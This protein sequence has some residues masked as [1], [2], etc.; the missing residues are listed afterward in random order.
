MGMTATEKIFARASGLASVKAGET[1]YP[2]PEVVI[3]HDG[4]V[5]SSKAQMDERGIPK[6][7][8]AERVVFATDHAVIYTTPQ[9]VARGAAIRKAVAEWGVKNFYDVGQGGHG[10]IFPMEMG[11]VS[12][13]TFAFAND[14]H[15]SNNGAIGAVVAR[16]G[17]EIVCV[18]ATGTLWIEVPFSIKVN[19]TGKLQDG[20]FG[21]DFGYRVARNFTNGTFKADWDYRV[22]E[23]G[24]PALEHLNLAQ[25]VAMCNTLT[26]IG[27]A[28]VFFPPSQE[29]IQW[30]S[31]RARRPF[32]PVYSDPDAHYEAEFTFDLGTLQPQIV[33]PGAPDQ[34]ADI[35][36][37]LGRKVDHAYVGSCGSGMY[38]DLQVTARALKGRKV[39]SGTRLFIVP[40]TVASARRMVAEGL[41]DIFQE[42]GAIILPAGCGPCT[43]G[44]GA[45]LAAGE[46]SICTAATNYAGRMGDKAAEIYLA[47]PATVACSAVEGKITDPRTHG[48]RL[49]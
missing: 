47:S 37:A 43:K 35:G 40:G 39:A 10:H 20:V 4:Y 26:E 22:I 13:G 25:R 14:S 3:V 38:E 45:P 12:P 30:A 18:M 29:I 44:T 5:A 41:M 15:C 6:L 32:T 8:D 49:S 27:V 24:G 36:E 1:V 28:N 17:T 7:F 48:V 19:L 31:E 2:D 16:T 42:A 11:Y 33:L 21:R 34:A 9:A 46:V 23:F